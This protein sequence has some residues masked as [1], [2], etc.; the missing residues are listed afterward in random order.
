MED[1]FAQRRGAKRRAKEFRKAVERLMAEHTAGGMLEEQDAK[2]ELADIAGV[3]EVAPLDDLGCLADVLDDIAAKPVV[4]QVPGLDTYTF[5][6]AEVTA[7]KTV[8]WDAAA[9]TKALQGSTIVIAMFKPPV[10]GDAPAEAAAGELV[11]ARA[12]EAGASLPVPVRLLR[13][14]LPN[15]TSN[16][17]GSALVQAMVERGNKASQTLILAVSGHAFVTDE[18]VG[19]VHAVERRSRSKDPYGFTPVAAVWAWLASL[20]E[21]AKKL[22]PGAVFPDHVVLD[23]CATGR[24]PG[25]GNPELHYKDAYG[26]E[27][28]DPATVAATASWEAMPG[29]CATGHITSPPTEDSLSIALAALP[30]TPTMTY[31]RM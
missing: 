14:G 9:D 12:E 4:E 8:D 29:V 21:A 24:V 16:P 5:D 17:I 18:A 25:A 6:G 20:H 28:K 7:R 26:L 27:A 10:P 11:A 1:A 13:D 22:S 30:A 31:T 15:G 2:A 23:G 3:E 19:F